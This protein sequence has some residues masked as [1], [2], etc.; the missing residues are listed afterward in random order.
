[1]NKAV[2][3]GVSERTLSLAEGLINA[4]PQCKIFFPNAVSS[5][6][7][8]GYIE[9]QIS[10]SLDL[11]FEDVDFVV[12][13]QSYAQG[14]ETVAVLRKYLPE[15]ALVLELQ[16]VKS[17]FYA[18]LQA[19]LGSICSVAGS[20]TFADTS[21]GIVRGDL[22]KDKITA[23]ICD[24][25]PS[26]LER[27]RDFWNLL[28]AK[29]I[30]TSA[31]FF[32]EITANTMGGGLLL[33]TMYVQILQRDSWA[34]TLFFG[35]YDRALRQA[36]GGV[37]KNPVRDAESIIRNKE[38]IGHV[39]T[40]LKREIQNLERILAEESKEKLALYLGQVQKFQDRL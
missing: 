19:Q 28:G 13:D 38:N 12:I 22:F 29:I 6:P 18:F 10:G 39:L 2:F 33:A 37:S 1:M 16:L 21:P 9:K 7:L 30:P 25:Q 23:I 27:L 34:D 32:D 4:Q 20:Y 40:F 3:Y 26:T 5:L 15:S 8:A 17:D 24:N 14:V 31:E 35:F 36:T 11:F